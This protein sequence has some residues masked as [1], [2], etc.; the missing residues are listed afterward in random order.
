MKFLERILEIL[1]C[2]LYIYFPFLDVPSSL[3]LSFSTRRWYDGFCVPKEKREDGF[4]S[5]PAFIQRCSFVIILAPG[6][7]H[8]DKVDPKI[9]RKM[10]LTN[11]GSKACCGNV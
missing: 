1:D 3:W 4:R 11:G 5:I 9:G 6:C 10:N 2:I 7:T 8:F